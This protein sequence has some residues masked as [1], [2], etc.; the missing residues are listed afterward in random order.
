MADM[1]K[2]L[3]VSHT[4]HNQLLTCTSLYLH[5]KYF[6]QSAFYSILFTNV[7]LHLNCRG[8][9]NFSSSRPSALNFQKVCFMAS[10]CVYYSRSYG[11]YQNIDPIK[12]DTS[13]PTI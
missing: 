10:T 8:L 9:K 6:L 5:P 1:E 2:N 7:F 13:L 4:L 12:F 11:T 3:Q